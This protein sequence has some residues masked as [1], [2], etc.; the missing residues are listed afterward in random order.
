MD[1]S[2]VIMEG[3][4]LLRFL[5]FQRMVAQSLWKVVYFRDFCLL[6][7][8]VA[9]SLWKVLYCRYFCYSNGWQPCHYERY[10][11]VDIFVTPMDG[12]LV[13]MEGSLLSIF[14]LLQWMV[15]LS[16]WKVFCCRDFYYSIG[17]QAYNHGRQS[18]IDIFVTIID[19]SL[20]IMEGSLLSISLLVQWMVAL[21]LWKVVCR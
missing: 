13:I 17:W 10:Y 19:G 6:Q 2:L 15:A 7:W 21:S 20:F 1:G 11:I 14:L 16:L 9:L 12:I 8:M 5:L 18:I 3:S 4:L